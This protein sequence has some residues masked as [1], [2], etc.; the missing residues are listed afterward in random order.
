[1][2]IPT[3]ITQPVQETIA[4]FDRLFNDALH[5]H[6]PEI[7]PIM[8][9]IAAKNGKR[10]RP[11][12]LILSASLCGETNQ[13][14]LDYA[15]ILEL[16][17]TATLIHDDVVD[18]AQER[19]AH[20]SVNARF[21]NRMA[22][23]LGDYVLT[24][25]IGRAVGVKNSRMIGIISRLAQNLTEGEL[26]QLVAAN[27]NIVD[28]GRYFEVI[29]KKTAVLFAAC[30]EMGALSAG[31]A[32]A[33][34]ERLR[35]TGENM[36]VCFQIKDD[37]FDYLDR[38]EIGKPVGNDIR[39]G[40]ITLPLVYA[41]KTT[42]QR[43]AAPMLN[44]I[45]NR[46]FTQDNIRQLTDFALQHGGVSYARVRMQE[47]KAATIRLLDTFPDSEARQAMINLT[48]YIIERDK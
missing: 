22:V 30:A 23:L 42:P 17:H 9:F 1:M 39:E 29:R 37:I 31:A 6:D 14:T 36:G 28:E 44:I 16:L 4:A 7:Q 43:I 47:I 21:D 45:H 10:I 13:Q 15:L 34:R 8:D 24:M 19:R 33:I 12:V 25:A 26:S 48:D 40:K 27:K 2:D 35:Q 46:N 38:G 20:P 11:A 5:G 32:P 3:A 18:N 41:L